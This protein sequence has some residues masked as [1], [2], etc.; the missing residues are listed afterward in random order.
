MRSALT[1]YFLTTYDVS[2]IVL[3]QQDLLPLA[4]TILRTAITG[5]N[6]YLRCDKRANPV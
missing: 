5:H 3:R 2:V 6:I 1:L 4:R